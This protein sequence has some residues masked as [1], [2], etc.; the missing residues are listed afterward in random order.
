MNVQIPAEA[1]SNLPKLDHSREGRGGAGFL[2]REDN[3]TLTPMTTGKKNRNEEG[4]LGQMGEQVRRRRFAAYNK[5][6]LHAASQVPVG[7]KYKA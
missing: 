6:W 3:E 1:T 2:Q 4:R 7:Y 5:E